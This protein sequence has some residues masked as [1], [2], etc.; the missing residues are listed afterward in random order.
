MPLPVE[1]LGPTSSIAQINQA[2]AESIEMCQGEGQKREVCSGKVYRMAEQATGKSTDML[3]QPNMAQQ[4][5][6]MLGV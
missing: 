1:S 4:G 5:Q 3:T 6:S 2:I